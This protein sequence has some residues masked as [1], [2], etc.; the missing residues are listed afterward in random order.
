MVCVSEICLTGAHGTCPEHR[1][2]KRDSQHGVV[3]DLRLS[4]R[5]AVLG[6]EDEL[7]C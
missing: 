6:D 3:L 1:Q 4:Q 5:R 7:G 2:E